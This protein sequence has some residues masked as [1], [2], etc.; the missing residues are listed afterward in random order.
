[1][2]VLTKHNPQKGGRFRFE[3]V[4][5]D[6]ATDIKQHSTDLGIMTEGEL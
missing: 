4:L 2:G 1:M 3:L 5:S 6:K